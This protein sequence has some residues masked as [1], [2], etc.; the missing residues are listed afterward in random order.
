MRCYVVRQGDYMAQLAHRHGFDAEEV[1]NHPENREVA[2]RRRPEMLHPGDMLRIPESPS[3]SH[4][5]EQGTVNRFRARVPRVTV[6]L[7]AASLEGPLAEARYEVLGAGV[8]PLQGTT[9][10]T[11]K[12]TLSVPI[13]TASV[14]VRFPEQRL[15]LRVFVGHLDPIGESSGLFQRLLHL[16]YID[17][18][19]GAPG[20]GGDAEELARALRL[21]QK[22]RGLAPTGQCDERTREALLEAHGS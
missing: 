1:W 21:F 4:P 3:I 17:R 9:D 12:L 6:H 15:T 8:E 16:G 22:E 2:S 5:I 7:I 10:R 13:S 14:D 20:H 19:A 11:G 18:P